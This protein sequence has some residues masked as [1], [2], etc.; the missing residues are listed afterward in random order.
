MKLPVELAD[1]RIHRNLELAEE[2]RIS[3]KL[4]ALSRAKRTERKAERRLL[5]AWQARSALEA[6]FGVE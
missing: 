2:I 6:T 3:R 5:Q 1:E 4:R